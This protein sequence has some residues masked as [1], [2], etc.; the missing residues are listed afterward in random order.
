ME[1]NDKQKTFRAI[2]V[3]PYKNEYTF[4][5]KRINNIH[6]DI[7]QD[8]EKKVGERQKAKK[9][10]DYGR[11][12]LLL[13]ELDVGFGVRVD[14]SKKEWH[15]MKKKRE[16]KEKDYKEGGNPHDERFVFSNDGSHGS[17]DN[18]KRGEVTA[19]R[20]QNNKTVNQTISSDW[21]IVD[22]PLEYIE[23]ELISGVSLVESNEENPSKSPIPVG[24]VIDGHAD[25]DMN[26]ILPGSPK[27][28]FPVPDGIVIDDHVAD[29]NGELLSTKSELESLT[30]P[31]LKDKLREKGLPVSGRKMELIERLIGGR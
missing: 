16:D 30:V 24:I 29:N 23:P 21:S 5:G 7:L 11:A 22:D 14:D 26:T 17:N 13:E 10:K 18:I 28:S 20:Q 2:S 15:F 25:S 3:D 19:K 27:Y 12:D 31:L 1:V 8:I 4:G 6:P 9:D